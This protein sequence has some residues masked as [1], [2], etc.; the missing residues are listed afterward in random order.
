MNR[1]QKVV[2][3]ALAAAAAAVVAIPLVAPAQGAKPDEA[4][5]A[6]QSIM[7][8]MG[9]NFGPLGKMASGDAPFDKNAFQTNAERLASIWA[10]NPAQYFVPGT[11]KPV[12]GSKIASFTAAKSE[13]WS[14]QD[15][16][17]AA[18]QRAGE[19]ISKLAEA[20]KSGDE[21][22]MKS[23]AGEVGKSCKACHDDF[24]AK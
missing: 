16:F 21:G 11:D 3:A 1:V 5:R 14:Q 19:Q 22:A 15:K 18:A 4:I 24:R 6:R 23:A 9:L 8:V 10:M 17:K 7:R 20:A 13:I 2:V 12:S